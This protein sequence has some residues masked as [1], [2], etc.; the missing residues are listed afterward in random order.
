MKGTNREHRHKHPLVSKAFGGLIRFSALR[1]PRLARGSFAFSTTHA[2]T[3]PLTS[4]FPSGGF[5]AAEERKGT[6]DLA[7]SSENRNDPPGKPEAFVKS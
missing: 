3:Y 2:A 1:C 4:S 6:W 5:A 7:F